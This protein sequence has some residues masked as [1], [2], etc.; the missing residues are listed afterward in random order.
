MAKSYSYIQ[1]YCRSPVNLHLNPH[2]WL[3]NKAKDY[4]ALVKIQTTPDLSGSPPS[5][6]ILIE[7]VEALEILEIA[8]ISPVSTLAISYQRDGVGECG[9]STKLSLCLPWGLSGVSCPSTVSSVWV[10]YPSASLFL[11]ELSYPFEYLI[12]FKLPSQPST[13]CSIMLCNPKPLSPIYKDPSSRILLNWTFE[14]YT[15][16]HVRWYPGTCNLYFELLVK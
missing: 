16:L 9:A 2:P 3:D 10:L 1:K 7:V 15:T 4:S 5:L 12:I 11:P 6:W 14:N 13:S 8:N